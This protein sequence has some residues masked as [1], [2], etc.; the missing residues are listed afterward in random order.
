MSACSDKEPTSLVRGKVAGV[1]FDCPEGWSLRSDDE[2]DSLTLL[3]DKAVEMFG[4]AMLIQVSR[5]ELKRS[6]QTTLDDLAKSAADERK[7]KLIR[8]ELL[9]HARH[10]KYGLIEYSYIDG[11]VGVTER[12]VVVALPAN[13]LLIVTMKGLRG[14]WSDYEP[15]FDAVIASL[16]LPTTTP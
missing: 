11:S 6:V 15:D 9:T 12:F 14:R 16:E 7:F 10:F 2:S 1:S 4:P 8:N 13:R 5:D 3:H